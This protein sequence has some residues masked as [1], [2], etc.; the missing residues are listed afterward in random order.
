MIHQLPKELQVI[1]LSILT[2]RRPMISILDETQE[3]V[4]TTEEKLEESAQVTADTT[5][6]VTEDTAEK[7]E[8]ML[9]INY[10]FWSSRENI[11]SQNKPLSWKTMPPLLQALSVKK[12]KK[13]QEMLKVKF[14]FSGKK[15]N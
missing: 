6:N 2:D 12:W 5:A 7:V 11:F 13:Q 3:T 15:T 10:F 1:A 8:G 14:F 9:L 4:A